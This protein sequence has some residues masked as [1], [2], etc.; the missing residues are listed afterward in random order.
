MKPLRTRLDLSRHC[1][2]TAIRRRH[3]RLVRRALRSMAFAQPLE[4][5]IEL[6]KTAMERFDF[7]W[8]RTFHPELAGTDADLVELEKDEKGNPRIRINGRPVDTKR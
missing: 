7:S 8:L 6:L 4:E 1:I 5:E 2:E 3:S